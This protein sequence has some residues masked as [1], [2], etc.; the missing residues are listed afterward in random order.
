M[1]R[2]DWSRGSN[3]AEGEPLTPRLGTRGINRFKVA[4]QAVRRRNRQ[5]K[6]TVD[7]SD[8]SR[9]ERGLPGSSEQGSIQ[10]MQTSD[11]ADGGALDKHSIH[12]SSD[13]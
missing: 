6:E 1:R 9:N 11:A 7:E 8:A 2:R 13:K 10:G 12:S 5:A 3:R 4:I